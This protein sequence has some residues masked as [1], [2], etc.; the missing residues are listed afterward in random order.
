MRS[1][2]FSLPRKGIFEGEYQVD[3]R[4]QSECYRG[5]TSQLCEVLPNQY[6]A[7]PRTLTSASLPPMAV[8]SKAFFWPKQ[9]QRK[10]KS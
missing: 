4:E 2:M 5:Q 3:D 6:F 1:S 7:A 9:K 8:G 10:K